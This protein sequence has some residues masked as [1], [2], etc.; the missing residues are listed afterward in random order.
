MFID[1]IGTVN[2]NT[3]AKITIAQ[4]ML[5]E[6]DVP[7]SYSLAQNFPNPF[8]PTTII[9]YELPKAGNVTLKVYNLLGREV[10]ILVK[11]EKQA[12]RYSVIFDG[13]RLASGEYIVRMQSG[14]Y[15][16]SM[17]ILLMK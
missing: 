3:L 2:E 6:P 16:K 7:E 1:E 12:G 15:L 4:I 8:N 5:E 11:G 10:A 13:S 17:K 14:G 9:R